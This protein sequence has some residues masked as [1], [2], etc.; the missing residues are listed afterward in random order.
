M[1]ENQAAFVVTEDDLLLALAGDQAAARRLHAKYS[2]LL[3]RAASRR[4]RRLPE[5]LHEEV[6]QEVWLLLFQR[7]GSGRQ[8]VTRPTKD[9]LF[10]LLGHA[11]DAVRAAYRLPGQRAR[12]RNQQRPGAARLPALEAALSLDIREVAESAAFS[13]EDRS[14]AQVEARHDLTVVMG[15]AP[16]DIGL[17]LKLMLDLDISMNAASERTGINRSR[18]QR[19]ASWVRQNAA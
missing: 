4:V 17:T 8:A 18:P 12:F 10:S 1:P 14:F 19:W 15:K 3:H 13:S 9:L 5:D 6:V 2:P 11:V 7:Y 16:S